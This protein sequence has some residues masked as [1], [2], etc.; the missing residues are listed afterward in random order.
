M[1]ELEAILVQNVIG[2]ENYKVRY[3]DSAE[4]I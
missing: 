3:Y 2:D 4:D 1:E